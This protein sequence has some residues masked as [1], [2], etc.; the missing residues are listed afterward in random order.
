MTLAD[1]RSTESDEN[2]SPDRV[3]SIVRGKNWGWAFAACVAVMSARQASAQDDEYADDDPSA[4]V[5]FHAALDPYGDWVDDAQ[6]GTVWVPNPEVVGADFTPYVT[7]GHWA[8]GDDYAWVSD[9]DWGWA[10]FHYGRW[11]YVDGRGWIWVAG[12]E[13]APSWV[14]WQVGEPGATY[15]G[16]APAPPVFVWRGGIAVAIGQP[17][18]APKYVFCGAGDL[19]NPHPVEV[20]LRGPEVD[21]VAGQMHPFEERPG[22]GS[23]VFLGPAPE[24]LGIDPAR[25]VHFTGHEPGF[26]HAR[27]FARPSVAVRYGGRPATAHVSVVPAAHPDGHP[28]QRE[29]GRKDGPPAR[30]EEQPHRDDVPSQRTPPH[31]DPA[32]TEHPPPNP[33]NAQPARAA[34]AAPHHGR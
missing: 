27:A 31:R 14:T 15:V 11:T 1:K 8:Y 9:Y 21:A 7:A 29:P 34:R 18:V 13:Y 26:V 22:S 32:T 2:M 4:L 6:D 10:P 25:V 33:D 28:V 19:F 12:R 16:W 23:R 17:P 30:R 20:V 5:D 24:R 3:V